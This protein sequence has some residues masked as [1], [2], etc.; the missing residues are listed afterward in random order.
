MADNPRELAAP[1]DE[2][3]RERF[4]KGVADLFMATEELRQMM[5]L[6]TNT[7]VLDVEHACA[8]LEHILL[9]LE[10]L[11]RWTD[12]AVAADLETDMFAHCQEKTIAV[13]RAVLERAFQSD[14]EE[15][16]LNDE[17]QQQLRQ[18]QE[19][20]ARITELNLIL[21]ENARLRGDKQVESTNSTTKTTTIIKDYVQYQ[22]SVLRRRV[23]PA[24]AQLVHV[25]RNNGD[26]ASRMR[27]AAGAATD[28]IR[29]YHGDDATLDDDDDEQES[30]HTGLYNTTTTVE[31]QHYAPVIATILGQAAALIHPLQLW[32]RNLQSMPSN[33]NATNPV[34]NCIVTMCQMS[35][36]TLDDQAQTLVKTVS[37]WL[38][39]DRPVDE[40][41]AKSAQEESIM[42]PEELGIL[43]GLVEETAF[44]CHV[45]ARYQTLL[46]GDLKCSTE[47][48]SEWTWKYA[49]L[50]RFLSVQQWQSALMMA[51]PVHIVMGTDIQVPSVVEDA[52][53]LSMRALERAASTQSMQAIGTVAH[54][55]SHDVWSTEMTG[56][57]YEAL[58]EQRGCWVE[59]KLETNNVASPPQSGFAS[60]LLDAL[61]DDLK[62]ALAPPPHAKPASAPSSGNFLIQIVKGGEE[63]QQVRLDTDFCVLNGVHAA[64]GACRALVDFLDDMLDGDA[65]VTNTHDEKS[66]AM[67]KLAREEFNRFAESYQILLTARIHEFMVIWCG[68]INDSP[69]NRQGLCFQQLQTFF[70]RED[71][72]LDA[73]TFELAD[74][75]ERLEQSMLAPLNESK[76]LAQLTYKCESNDV[77]KQVGI[78]IVCTIVDIVTTSV[79]TNEKQFSDWGSLLLSTQARLLQSFCKTILTP[80]S[81]EASGPDLLSYWERL[82]EVVAVLQL[83]KPSDWMAYSST[84]T[85]TTEEIND[86]L[87]LRVDFSQEAIQAVVAQLTKNVDALQ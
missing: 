85:L 35:M 36:E 4:S 67:I 63:L 13:A 50:E 86:T 54:A 3:A 83:E 38:W 33:D 32:K 53:Y 19:A 22:R 37:Q 73:D 44:G 70:D 77:L 18:E 59:P 65:Y 46:V 78:M 27:G 28:G 8:S 76:L 57:V 81:D 61:D 20:V 6:P 55:L 62:N 41:M 1:L 24:I 31:Q 51:A 82:S 30:K 5:I 9:I 17:H 49:T 26:T 74:K 56:G 71:Y 80:A 21:L 39:E 68:D 11:A 15:L 23:K 40:I 16:I 45:Q 87:R 69:E 14:N 10:T 25:R 58:L 48:L 66:K 12:D 42:D 84:S 2:H 43:D 52:Q 75:P 79:W 47:L 34:A 60:A 29:V 7:A 72:N 64:S